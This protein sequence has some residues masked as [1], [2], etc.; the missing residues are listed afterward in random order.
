MRSTPDRGCASAASRWWWG[1]APQGSSSRSRSSRRGYHPLVIDRGRA[2]RERWKDVNR[3]WNDGILDPESN[4]VFGDGG[5]GTFSDGKLYTRRNDPRNPYILG[6]LSEL[7]QAPEIITAGKPHLGTNRLSRALLALHER[8]DAAGVEIRFGARLE[9]LVIESGRVR[10]AIV[11]GERIETDT[12]FLAA[13]HSARDV[14]R[15][16]HR[17]KIAMEARPF[18]VGVRAEHPQALLNRA[19]LGAE[20]SDTGPADYML[21][22]NPPRGDRSAYTFCMCPGGEVVAAGTEADGLT[23]NG[24]SYSN[25]EQPF[26]NAAVVVTV[27]PEDFGASGP[28]AGLEFQR[29]LELKA[30]AA[31]GGGHVA[32]A[33]R[34]PD[35]LAARASTARIESSYRRGV[36][37]TDLTGLLPPDLVPFLRRGIRHFGRLVRGYDGPEG[38]LIGLETR[39]SSPVRGDARSGELPVEVGGRALSGRRRRGLCGRD[40]VERLGRAPRGGAHRGR[41]ELI[42]ADG[43]A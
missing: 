42:R 1:P 4:V 37:P 25:R 35:F 41:R 40:H 10:G 21:A 39:T 24:M 9:D 19:Q 43:A 17:H 30:Y 16:L 34:I 18:A 29:R 14:F 38:V 27:R 8:L 28:L 32:P 20:A 36:R 23:V 5:A 7:A 33:Q 2:L 22:Y 12:V 6:L 15:M 13:G 11:N 26:G 31:G 3:Y